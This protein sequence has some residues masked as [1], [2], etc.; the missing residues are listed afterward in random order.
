M[1][2]LGF[3]ELLIIFF[4]ILIFLGPSKLPELAKALGKGIREFQKAK[5]GIAQ[6]IH[7]EVTDSK[8]EKITAQ[9][10]Q[11]VE[12]EGKAKDEATVAPKA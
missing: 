7:R 9:Y 2:G 5:E 10:K 11:L 1:F 8:N 6:D 12:V 3:G 4:V